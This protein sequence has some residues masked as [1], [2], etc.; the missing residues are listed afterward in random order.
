MSICW[1]SYPT[2][3]H[4]QAWVE[5]SGPSPSIVSWMITPNKV[6]PCDIP[7]YIPYDT[8]NLWLWTAEKDLCRCDK[9]KD[10]EIRRSFW[11]T[12][13]GPNPNDKGPYK[14]HTEEALWRVRGWSD[15]ATHLGILTA[16]RSWK[17]QEGS[18][19][20]ASGRSSA[21]MTPFFSKYFFKLK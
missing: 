8:Q 9:I 1:E 7:Y 19:P 10:L 4:F 21:L 3:T 5:M 6:C 13:V 12:H 17:R 15:V 11:M 16:T 18:P 14:R 2:H 20:K